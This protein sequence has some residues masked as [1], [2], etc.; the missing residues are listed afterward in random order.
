MWFG[1]NCDHM[2][3]A[4]GTR[5]WQAVFVVILIHLIGPVLAL[6]TACTTPLGQGTASA[7]EPFWLETIDHRYACTF[8]SVTDTLVETR[9]RYDILEVCLLSMRIAIHILS[10]AMS[11]HTV[12][13]EMVLQTIR[14]RSSLGSLYSDFA[15]LL[16]Y[17]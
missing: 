10:F 5:Y 1:S 11:N 13:W 17:I 6:G 8:Q 9:S 7:E 14:T 12:R 3:K 16:N 2:A 4:S 15:K